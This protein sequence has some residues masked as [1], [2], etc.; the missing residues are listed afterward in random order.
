MPSEIDTSA[1]PSVRARLSELKLQQP[2][3]SVTPAIKRPP[4][5]PPPTGTR[6]GVSAL[7]A[8]KGPPQPPPHDA[9]PF[10]PALPPRRATTA[11]PDVTAAARLKRTNVR[12]TRRDIAMGLAEFSMRRLLPLISHLKAPTPL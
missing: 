2:T 10:K 6:A 4:P 5:P 12:S 1:V 7:P 8:R 11:K 9:E 3:S